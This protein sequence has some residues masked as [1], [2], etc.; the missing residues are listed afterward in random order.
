MLE[1]LYVAQCYYIH[2]ELNVSYV[3]NSAQ[4]HINVYTSVTAQ[5]VSHCTKELIF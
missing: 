1:T 2:S 4:S 5:H 3:F